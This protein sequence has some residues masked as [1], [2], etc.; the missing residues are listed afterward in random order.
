MS[1]AL[2]YSWMVSVRGVFGMVPRM[3]GWG[4]IWIGRVSIFF[5]LSLYF[6]TVCLFGFIFFFTYSRLSFG[7]GVPGDLFLFGLSQGKSF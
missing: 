1:V 6:C 5:V 2:L 4:G 7:V 3:E